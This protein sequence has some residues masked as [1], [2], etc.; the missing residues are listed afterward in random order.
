MGEQDHKSRR[1]RSRKG[2][3][4]IFAACLLALLA[5]IGGSLVDSQDAALGT[6]MNESFVDLARYAADSGIEYG[7]GV[8]E[9]EINSSDFSSA[10]PR[11]TGPMSDPGYDPVD[12]MDWVVH[13]GVGEAQF[14]TFPF[15]PPAWDAAQ[16]VDADGFCASRYRL[17]A[18][19]A[20]YPT[21][22]FTNM[23]ERFEDPDPTKR[24][25]VFS[26][27]SRGEVRG[28]RDPNASILSPTA[29][30]LL[31]HSIVICTFRVTPAPP[32]GSCRDNRQLRGK[33]E[34]LNYDL[35]DV[36]DGN[37]GDVFPPY[38]EH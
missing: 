9:S 18:H 2:F 17:Q 35:V 16:P 6:L 20:L 26:L 22:S 5:I 27:R 8:I 21:L 23:R 30:Q 13:D 31:S 1:P 4:I 34:I 14:A 19:L 15:Y 32:I 3:L 24:D 25:A 33:I 12:P 7:L 37:P 38:Q 11:L 10:P 28:G 36:R 29:I